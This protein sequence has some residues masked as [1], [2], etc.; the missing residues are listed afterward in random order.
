MKTFKEAIELLRDLHD[1][2]GDRQ[3]IDICYDEMKIAVEDYTSF[4]DWRSDLHTRTDI[5][6]DQQHEMDCHETSFAILFALM[7]K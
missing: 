2:C 6:V 7:G 1:A 5:S 3:A 4:E